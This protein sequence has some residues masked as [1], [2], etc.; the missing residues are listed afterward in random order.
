[1]LRVNQL[2]PWCSFCPPKTSRAAY[3]QDN[4]KGKFCCEDH[5]EALSSIELLDQQI[6]SRITEADQSTWMRL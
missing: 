4:W 6:E 3:R 1:M 5:K 2:G